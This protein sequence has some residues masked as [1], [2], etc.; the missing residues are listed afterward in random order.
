MTP[1]DKMEV[2]LQMTLQNTILTSANSDLY[3]MLTIR[4]PD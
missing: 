3:S 4:I 1:S 2:A